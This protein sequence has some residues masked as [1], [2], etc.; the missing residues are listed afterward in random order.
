[1]P[2]PLG[3]HFTHGV[4]N[5]HK[6]WTSRICSKHSNILSFYKPDF[7]YKNTNFHFVTCRISII[8]SGSDMFSI[9]EGSIWKQRQRLIC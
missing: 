6:W 1:L 7:Y 4:L 9:H 5:L 8:W 3:I 2:H